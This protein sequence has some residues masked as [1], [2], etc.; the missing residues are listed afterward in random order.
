MPFPAPE[1]TL[2]DETAEIEI[3]TEAPAGGTHRTIIWVVVDGLDAFVR[4]VNGSTARWYREARAHPAVTIHVGGRALAAI[5][6]PAT[7]PDSVRRTSDALV[8]KYAGE[9]VD[10]NSMLV[11]G[12]LDTTLRLVPG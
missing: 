1:L 11:P 4:S 3:E 10:L 5:A 12:I 2:L 6:E 8:R 7:D 9:S